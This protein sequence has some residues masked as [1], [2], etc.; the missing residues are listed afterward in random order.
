MVVPTPVSTEAHIPTLPR[1]LF[2]GTKTLLKEI[3]VTEVLYNVDIYLT[4][5]LVI[6]T[7]RHCTVNAKFFFYFNQF[8]C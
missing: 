8:K 3:T 4:Q 6:L 5:A 2:S 7:L 1:P